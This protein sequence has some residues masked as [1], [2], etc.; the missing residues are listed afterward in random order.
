MNEKI[1]DAICNIIEAICPDNYGAASPSEAQ[2]V[3]SNAV[4]QGR[5]QDVLAYFA[6]AILDEVDRKM[7]TKEAA[8]TTTRTCER[9]GFLFPVQACGKH[10]V[11]STDRGLVATCSSPEVAAE[12][13]R[14]INAAHG[15]CA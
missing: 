1:N 14:L 15:G 6:A 4:E 13:V 7:A 9:L 2:G 12:F 3:P 5:L 11:D 8:N 10:V